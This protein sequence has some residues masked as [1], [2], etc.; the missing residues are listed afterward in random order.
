MSDSK[1]IK[2]PKV[3]KNTRI[4]VIKKG[5]IRDSLIYFRVRCPSEELPLGTRSSHEVDLLEPSTL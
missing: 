3:M 5:V 1:V 2:I 4:V